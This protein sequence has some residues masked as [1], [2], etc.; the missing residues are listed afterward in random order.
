MYATA[1]LRD[2]SFCKWY[3]LSFESHCEHFQREVMVGCGVA[4]AVYQQVLG[5]AYR[6]VQRS[7]FVVPQNDVEAEPHRKQCCEY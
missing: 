7:F 6:P 3:C 2:K 4:F 5:G 1:A